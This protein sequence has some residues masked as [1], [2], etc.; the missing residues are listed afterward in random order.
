[1]ISCVS[2]GFPTVG[3]GMKVEEDE[4]GE[5]TPMF[6]SDACRVSQLSLFRVVVCSCLLLLLVWCR[7]SKF[8]FELISI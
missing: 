1:M 7:V 4:D 3:R 2:L 5:D 8:L 6:S